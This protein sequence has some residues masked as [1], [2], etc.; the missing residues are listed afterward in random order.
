MSLL[1]IEEGDKVLHIHSYEK[2]LDE[3]TVVSKSRWNTTLENDNT[4]DQYDMLV[5]LDDPVLINAKIDYER[6]LCVQTLSH[7]DRNKLSDDVLEQIDKIYSM[8]TDNEKKK[9]QG[10]LSSCGA[11]KKEPSFLANKLKK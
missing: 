10:F 8:L 2:K 6:Y 9:T 4:V 7:I 5:R 1:P 3:T 11:L